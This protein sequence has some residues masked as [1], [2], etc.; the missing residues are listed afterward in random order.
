MGE[1]MSEA[2]EGRPYKMPNGTWATWVT[3]EPTVGAEVTVT[4]LAGK[5]WRATITEVGGTDLDTGEVLCQTMR[6]RGLVDATG[7]GITKEQEI[8]RLRKLLEYYHLLY[9][10]LS[11]YVG[12]W[13]DAN[14]VGEAGAY[15]DAAKANEIRRAVLAEL[16]RQAEKLGINAKGS[17]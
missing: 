9:R 4:S 3:G 16:E 11:E 8:Q 17:R 5:R 7:D 12:G 1:A 6:G 10:G 2:L 15:P 14:L 13:L